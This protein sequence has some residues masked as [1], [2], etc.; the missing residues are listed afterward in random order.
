MRNADNF[1]LKK[2]TGTGA[3]LTVGAEKMV[4]TIDDGSSSRWRAALLP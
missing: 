2:R 4:L 1:I 3:D